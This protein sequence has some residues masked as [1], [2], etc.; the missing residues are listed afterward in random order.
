MRKLII[1]AAIAAGLALGITACGTSSS[2]SASRPAPVTT[3]VTATPAA[4]ASAPAPA[5]SGGYTDATD[6]ATLSQDY[7][8][9]NANQNTTTLAAFQADLEADASGATDSPQLASATQALNSDVSYALDNNGATP[10]TAT[11]DEQAVVSACQAAGVTLP[12]SFT[13]S[14]T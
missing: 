1:T 12:A 6:C 4:T 3:T 8:A 14:G 2:S 13:S 11:A 9:F 7:S 10:S 5:N